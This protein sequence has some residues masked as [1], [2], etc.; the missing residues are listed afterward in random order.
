[1][2][3]RD[4][5]KDSAKP[6]ASPGKGRTLEDDWAFLPI[7][8]ASPL[9]SASLLHGGFSLDFLHIGWFSLEHTNVIQETNAETKW[10]FNDVVLKLT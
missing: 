8:R 2:E 6:C 4:Q 3:A 9:L 10:L 1:M 5:L 7:H